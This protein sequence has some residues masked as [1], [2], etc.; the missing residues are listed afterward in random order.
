MGPHAITVSGIRMVRTERVYQV[1]RR[2]D[3]LCVLAT[4]DEAVARAAFAKRGNVRLQ[5]LD[6]YRGLRVSD[7]NQWCRVVVAEE[8]KAA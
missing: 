5:T 6:A 7:M 1:F 2:R 3:G 8:Q 4:K